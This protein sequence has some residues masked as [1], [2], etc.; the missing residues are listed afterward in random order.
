MLLSPA[1]L[2]VWRSQ[3]LAVDLHPAPRPTPQVRQHRRMLLVHLVHREHLC[4]GQHLV[5][6]EARVVNDEAVRDVASS[7]ASSCG[8]G[9]SRRYHPTSAHPQA[10]S[11]LNTL[12][13]VTGC[14][15]HIQRCAVPSAS[16]RHT[17]T[18][19]VES[20]FVS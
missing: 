15:G 7:R 5:N 17:T 16:I 3:H 20:S 9:S 1:P 8:R 2:A 4:G 11:S 14:A 12:R 18:G 13:P 6:D 19:A 10:Q